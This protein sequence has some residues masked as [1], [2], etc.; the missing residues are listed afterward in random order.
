MLSAL[1]KDLLRQVLLYLPFPDVISCVKLNK[2]LHRMAKDEQLWESLAAE[3]W[4]KEIDAAKQR[5]SGVR[6]VNMSW[7]RFCR[8]LERYAFLFGFWYSHADCFGEVLAFN[9][10]CLPQKRKLEGEDQIGDENLSGTPVIVGYKYSNSFRTASEEPLPFLV[11]RAHNERTELVLETINLNLNL[12]PIIKRLNPS[13]VSISLLNYPSPATV[14]ERLSLEKDSL[15]IGTLPPL[16]TDFSMDFFDPPP[17]NDD[18]QDVEQME[19]EEF[20]Q[21][22]LVN[23]QQEQPS[24]LMYYY[25]YYV[26]SLLNTLSM[27]RGV[28]NKQNKKDCRADHFQSVNINALIQRGGN[29]TYDHV[30]HLMEE[31]T[32]VWEGN[33]GPHGKELILLT[34]SVSHKL[35]FAKKITGDASIPAGQVTWYAITDG[36]ELDHKSGKII[37]QGQGHIALHGYVNDEW[38]PGF[39][40]IE[41]KNK[42]TFTWDELNSCI[43]YS[44]CNILK[45]QNL[46][47][48][49]ELVQ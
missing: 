44:R 37:V 13:S 29:L 6:Y 35:F 43:S 1:P 39:L 12:T 34:L 14:Y 22:V 36:F 46:S 26:Q 2:S 10:V 41:H 17:A 28:S 5:A 7:R 18:A 48:Y 45:L 27:N 16:D 20:T 3:R 4:R 38:I 33:Y 8:I 31:L 40:T 9:L 11:M 21:P 32:G 24:G 25:N 49:E 47:P 30:L 42:L 23:T 19:V 15:I